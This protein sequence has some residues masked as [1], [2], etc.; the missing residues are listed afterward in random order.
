[1]AQFLRPASDVTTTNW[2]RSSGTSSYF[3]YINDVTADSSTYLQT[4]TQSSGLEIGLGGTVATPGSRD[5]H[6][7]RLQAWSL[8]SSAAE[9]HTVLLLQGSTTIATPVNNATLTR[10]TPTTITYTLTNAEATAITN[11]ADL[12]L[13]F[14]ATTLAASETYRVSWAELE[15]PDATVRRVVLIT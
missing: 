4:Q 13:R 9:R 11:Y 1:M 5:N 12:R 7:V 14:T 10:T 15:I 2:T 6:I 8:G 3:T